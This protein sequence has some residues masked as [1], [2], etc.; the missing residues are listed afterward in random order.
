MV[1]QPKAFVSGLANRLAKALNLGGNRLIVEHN[2][3]NPVTQHIVN[4]CQINEDAILLCRSECKQLINLYDDAEVKK[5][6]YTLFFPGMLKA[7][8]PFEK[9]MRW[10]PAGG[11]YFILAG[12]K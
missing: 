2:P 3:L 1:L 12:K 10:L 8:R 6:G 11:Q 5:N 7:L 4:T 9:W